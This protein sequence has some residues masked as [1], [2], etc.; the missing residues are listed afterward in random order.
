VVFVAPLVQNT[1]RTGIALSLMLVWM[2]FW[3]Y[4]FSLTDNLILA[5][6]TLFMV[7]IAPPTIITTSNGLLQVLSPPAMRA[8]LL[9][10]FVMVSFGMQPIA[11]F[12]I[13]HIADSFGVSVS[14]SIYAVGLIIGGILMVLR[15]GLRAWN[16]IAP[17]ATSAAAPAEVV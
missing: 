17:P 5:V 8:R 13:G 15:P 12:I 9:S 6:I 4:L 11:A 2:G 16:M 3:F 14:I 10:L 1:K 7:S